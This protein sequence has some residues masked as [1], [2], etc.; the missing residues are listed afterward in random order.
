MAK[1]L[2]KT[3]E[4]KN[5]FIDALEIAAA[6]SLLERVEAP[7]IGNGTIQSAIVKGII[8]IGVPIIGG[9][10]KLTT[11]ISTAQ[12]VD[13]MEDVINVAFKFV[14]GSMGSSGGSTDNWT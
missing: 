10:N 2:L 9:K 4:V 13:S 12:I 8:G 1:K 14:S 7:F 3:G 5:V 6:K 11:I